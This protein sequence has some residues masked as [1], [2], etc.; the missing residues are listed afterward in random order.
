MIRNRKIIF[1]LL[2]VTVS[3]VCIG[4][5]GQF[6]DTATLRKDFSRFIGKE[7]YTLLLSD[8]C[9]KYKRLTY[10]AEPPGTFRGAIIELPD[11]IS[12][13]FYIRK[14]RFLTEYNLTESWDKELLYKEIITSI[15]ILSNDKVI[16]EVRSPPIAPEENEGK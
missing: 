10:I 5:K 11:G 8:Y 7:V 12:I 9:R 2:F 15:F 16:L 14:V 4:Q 3:F 6:K 1:L 13:E